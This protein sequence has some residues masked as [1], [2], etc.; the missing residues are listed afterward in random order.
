[1]QTGFMLA[2]FG[3]YRTHLTIADSLVGSYSVSKRWRQNFDHGHCLLHV[4]L[5]WRLE[6]LV[7]GC[8]GGCWMMWDK[9]KSP[10]EQIYKCLIQYSMST[11]CRAAFI[12]ELEL[13]WHAEKMRTNFLRLGHKIPFCRALQLN[14]FSRSAKSRNHFCFHGCLKTR[15]SLSY[16][17]TSDITCL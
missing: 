14:S 13:L 12:R 4:E 11:N 16:K 5:L 3:P 8:L 7:S 17:F 15:I 2:I 6:V 1:M 9:A 10:V